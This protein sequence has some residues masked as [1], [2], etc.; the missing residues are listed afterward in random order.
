[1]VALSTLSGVF[2]GPEAGGL[3]TAA[4]TTDVAAKDTLLEELGSSFERHN[5]EEKD[6]ALD[7]LVQD[8]S[9]RSYISG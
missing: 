2:G 7:G 9:R 4:C 5:L 6:L 3:C 8:L 1:M